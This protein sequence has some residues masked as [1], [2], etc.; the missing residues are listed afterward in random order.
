MER[1]DKRIQIFWAIAVCLILPFSCAYSG[2]NILIEADFLCQ[3]L[4]FEA[5]DLVDLLADKQTHWEFLSNA[6]AFST[7]WVWEAIF[8]QLNIFSF[9]EPSLDQERS[10]LRC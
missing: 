1:K 7:P 10:I 2:Y 4:K 5:S 6:F 9:H 3:G 8:G